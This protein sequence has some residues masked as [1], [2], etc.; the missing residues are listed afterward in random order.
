[1][2]AGSP[3]PNCGTFI[4]DWLVIFSITLKVF[5]MMPRGALKI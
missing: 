1:M 4:D 3:W 5:K 2:G